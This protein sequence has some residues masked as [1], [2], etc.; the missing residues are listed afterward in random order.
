MITL[1]KIEPKNLHLIGHGFGAHICILISNKLFQ[2]CIGRT[3]R[4][5]RTYFVTI[6]RIT[7]NLN[8]IVLDISKHETT[9]LM[10]EGMQKLKNS[11]LISESFHTDIKSYG[12][13]E[14]IA[15]FEFFVNGGHGQP[16]CDSKFLDY[17]V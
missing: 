2:K 12:T 6:G 3:M 16:G 8:F 9:N 17:K 4:V 7:L 14:L 13:P 10:R 15:N 1:L 11:A 5:T